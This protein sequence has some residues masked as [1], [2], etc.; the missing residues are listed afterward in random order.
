MARR[1]L[2][3]YGSGDLSTYWQVD[4]AASILRVFGRGAPLVDATYAIELYNAHRFQ[5]S[6]FVPVS[7]TE[8]ERTALAEESGRARI[9][10]ARFF[11]EVSE[12]NVRDR[13]RGVPREY[14]PD[15]LTLLGNNRAFE[16]CS[17]EVMLAVLVDNDIHLSEMLSNKTL[18]R[19]YDSNL[20]ELL[21]NDSK[22]AELLIRQLFSKDRRKT[23]YLPRSLTAADSRALMARYIQAKDANSNYLR[24][25]ETAPISEKVTGVDAR[26]KLEARRRR[27]RETEAIFKQN[28]GIKSGAELRIVDDQ[29]EPVVSRLDGMVVHS[30]YSRGWLEKTTD[31]P[32]VLNNF[33][34]LFEFANENVLLLLPSHQAELGVFER[35][36]MTTGQTDYHVGAA[37]RVRDIMSTLQTQLV[38]HFLESQD[39]ELESVV[40]WFFHDYLPDEFAARG[41]SFR[42]SARGSSF[43]EKTRHLLV[44]MESVVRQFALYAEDGCIDRE[45]LGIASDNVRYHQIPSLLDSKYLYSSHTPEIEGI[46]YALFSDQ[47]AMNYISEDLQA[48]DLATLLLRNRV[49]YDQFEEHQRPTLDQL[50]GLGVLRNSGNRVQIGSA[51]QFLI[52]RSLVSNEAASYVHLT[53]RGRAAAD[54]MVERGWL[55]LAATLLTTAEAGYFNYQL[56]KS[57]FHNGPEIRNKYLHGSQADLDGPGAHFEAYITTLKLTIA[58]I[59]KINDDFASAAMLIES[60]EHDL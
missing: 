49:T 16:R 10:V 24:L 11:T 48:D 29:E 45:L 4:D 47:S 32:S 26:L 15:V 57:Q 46:L 25:I 7:T 53:D 44:E 38:L 27:D 55:R 5:D 56:N 2:R 3:Y 20:R 58:L 6:G 37:Y 39:V 36:M 22:N 59:I 18:V 12:S 21:L 1:R 17:A 40:S 9:A 43:L 41:F 35:F 8:A 23:R 13:I 42:A 19:A 52:L 60:E 51:P 30:S 28:P 34:H 50:I 14:H 31:N 33:Q 54:E